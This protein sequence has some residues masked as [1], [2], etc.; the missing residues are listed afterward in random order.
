MADFKRTL[1]EGLAGTQ[2]SSHHTTLELMEMTAST[3][4]DA[5]SRDAEML[6]SSQRHLSRHQTQETPAAEKDG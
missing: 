5:G 6:S 4:M 3:K 1:G 2:S